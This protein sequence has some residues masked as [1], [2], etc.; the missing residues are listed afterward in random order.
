MLILGGHEDEKKSE[1]RIPLKVNKILTPE[2][3][4]AMR[5]GEEFK[6]GLVKD[7]GAKKVKCGGGEMSSHH[8]KACGKFLRLTQWEGNKN[9][10]SFMK[11]VD[12]FI[13]GYGGSS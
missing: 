1:E 8:K 12:E 3:R 13:T 7:S 5:S 6:I 10:A 4:I 11:R 2:A 9:D